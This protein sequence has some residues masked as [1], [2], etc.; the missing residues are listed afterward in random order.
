MRLLSIN[1]PQPIA[2]TSGVLGCGCGF[3]I[4]EG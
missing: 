1:A 4:Y 3:N 2:D